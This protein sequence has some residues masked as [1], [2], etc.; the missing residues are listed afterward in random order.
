MLIAKPIERK[1]NSLERQKPMKGKWVLPCGALL[2]VLILSISSCDVNRMNIPSL[3]QVIPSS[4]SFWP[5]SD[6]DQRISMFPYAT[7]VKASLTSPQSDEMVVDTFVPLVGKVEEVHRLPSKVVWVHVEYK[8]NQVSRLPSAIDYYLPLQR[9][10]FKQNI[11]LFKGKGS[12]QITIHLPDENEAER[13]VPIATFSVT[14]QST[15]LTRDVEYTVEGLKHQLRLNQP[16]TG[17]TQNKGMVWLKGKVSLQDAHLLIQV[18]KGKQSWRRKI[19]VKDQHFT[20]PIPLLFGKGLHEVQV[21]LPDPKHPNTFV[22]GASF[23]IENTLSVQRTPITYTSLYEERGIQLT[24]P[25][26]GGEEFDLTAR[27]AGTID[28][29][30]TDA[31]RTT[32]LIARVKKGNLEATYFLPVKNFRFDSPIW[33][34][35]GPGTY[36]V[37]L[38]VPEITSANRDYF[39]FF[40]VAQYEVKSVAKQDL[41]DLLP[42]RGIESDHKEMKRLAKEITQD[43]QTDRE[44]AKAIYLYVARTM[45]Y[46]TEKFRKNTFAWDDSAL[47]SLQTRSGV[48]QDYVFLTLALLRSLEIPS[49][50]VEG[51][52]GGQR[53]A[54]VEARLDGRWVSMDPTWGSGYMTSDGRFIKKLDERYF[55]PPADSFAKTHKRM[56][57]VY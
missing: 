11:R 52:A 15:Q 34:R 55:D 40:A 17:Y 21:M 30:A 6:H 31:K 5:F 9:G 36:Q 54:W 50:F 19:A 3:E 26:A 7:K 28:P 45:N 47:K 39:R 38:Y 33:L 25:V 51:E 42:S 35:F 16:Q 8:G 48:C 2:M 23:F 43:A 1:R 22:N 41:R 46:D 10:E 4:S 53:H 56:G 37:T 29:N 18:R 27:I 32:H 14:N 12:Y 13:F 49:R 57:I 44:K 20:E 24:D